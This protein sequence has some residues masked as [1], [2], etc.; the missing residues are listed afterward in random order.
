MSRT[1]GRA[2]P[3]DLVVQHVELLGRVLGDAV[4]VDRRDRML[5]VDGEV[6]RLAEDLTRR[7]VDHDRIDVLAAQE[8]EERELARRVHLQV[9]HRIVHRVD[10]A[11]LTREVEHDVGVDRRGVHVV[12]T[13]LTEIR[14]DHRD[15]RVGITRAVGHQ[16]AGICAVARHETHRSP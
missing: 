15:R 14:V 11:D 4:H 3:V 12:T 16:I 5:L 1:D 7:R 8:F 10:V 2:Q 6:P 9:E 13:D